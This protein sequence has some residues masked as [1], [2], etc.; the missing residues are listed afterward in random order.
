MHRA[1]HIM[2]LILFAKALTDLHQPQVPSAGRRKLA[3][4]SLWQG[5]LMGLRGGSPYAIPGREG[6]QPRSP[7]A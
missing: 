6:N 7:T 3:D 1:S 5:V 2:L 4:D